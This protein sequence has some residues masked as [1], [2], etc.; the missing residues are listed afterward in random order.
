MDST[1]D[2]QPPQS[3]PA[4]CSAPNGYDRSFVEW[5]R[6]H[7]WRVWRHISGIEVW[8]FN[9]A[10]CPF[11]VTDGMIERL[12]SVGWL[13]QI[14]PPDSS[15]WEEWYQTP[16]WMPDSYAQNEPSSATRGTKL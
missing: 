12:K 9:D 8:T 4:S 5:F 10:H 16:E 6:S 11:R 14:F 2:S 7:G 13:V 1:S 3:A 15:I